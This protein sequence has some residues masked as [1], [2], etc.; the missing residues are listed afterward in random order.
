MLSDVVY[1]EG[2]LHSVKVNSVTLACLHVV[3][4]RFRVVF[5]CMHAPSGGQRQRMQHPL[6]L[7]FFARGTGLDTGDMAKVCP[8]T[9]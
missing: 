7:L 8:W 9:S 6:P 3:I 5:Y 1:L 2:L 4:N